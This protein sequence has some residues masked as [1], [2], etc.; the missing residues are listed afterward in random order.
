MS[1]VANSSRQGIGSMIGRRD[2]FQAQQ[3]LNHIVDLPLIGRPRPD[4]SQLDLAGR[5]LGKRHG[6]LTASG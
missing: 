2:F 1:G 4:T 6:C 3:L 5:I